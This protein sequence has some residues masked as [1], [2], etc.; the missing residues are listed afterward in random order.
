MIHTKLMAG[1][2]GGLALAIAF[3]MPAMSQTDPQKPAPLT[4]QQKAAKAAA[5]KAREAQAQPVPAH[6]TALLKDTHG[7]SVGV[8]ELTTAPTGLALS[9]RLTG[10]PPVVHAFHIH[11]KGVCEGD[12]KTAG[13]HFN[14]T[15]AHHGFMSESGQHAGDM[16]NIDVPASGAIDLELFLTGVS[17]SPASTVNLL[18]NDGSSF[19]IHAGPDDYKSDPAGN[20]GGRIACGVIQVKK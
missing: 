5:E 16:P 20:A 9:A 3:A 19:V 11:E 17:L 10:L 2:A 6:A 7:K 1:A 12:F 4:E 18:D 13:G 15:H 8:V 14:P